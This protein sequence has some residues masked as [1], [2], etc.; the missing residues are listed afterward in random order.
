[1]LSV[2]TAHA[3]ALTGFSLGDAA[4]YAVIFQG[5]GGNSLQINA[6]PA[7]V[8]GMA[9]NGNVG[10]AGTGTMGPSGGGGVQ[11]ISGNV[12]FYGTANSFSSSYVGGSINSGVSVVQTAM[13]YMNSLSSILG[14][15]TGTALSLGNGTTINA[16]AGTVDVFGNSVFNATMT[17]DLSG[18]TGIITVNGD[19]TH[20]VVINVST[21]KNFHPHQIVLTGGLTPDDILWN[22]Y[23][24]NSGTLSGG[25][26][27]N[28]NSGGGSPSHTDYVLQGVFLDPNG[29]IS[30]S[31]TQLTGRLYGGDTHNMS[32]VSG[33]YVSAPP[34]PPS[35]PD[36]GST[37]ML[38]G[39]A[40]LGLGG[41]SRKLCR[42]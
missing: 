11:L 6:G 22:F 42:A 9:V 7:L 4:G 36:A 29:T 27:L 37:A 15:E 1:M 35:V 10:I 12:D 8:S 23:G 30:L 39:L 40:L 21:V 17:G 24:G 34:T 38:L 16:S 14:A 41:L 18:G 20:K 19:G 31:D 5:G 13:N 33:G 2:S 28:V 3:T 25:P 26:T 32:I